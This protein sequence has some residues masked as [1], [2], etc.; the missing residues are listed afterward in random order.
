MIELFGWNDASNTEIPR[1][2]E[3]FALLQDQTDP[4]KLRPAVIVVKMM[5][6]RQLTWAESDEGDVL[7][8]DIPAAHFHCCNGAQ[9]KYWKAVDI[10]QKLDSC[11]CGVVEAPNDCF[12][13]EL[14]IPP[15]PKPKRPSPEGYWKFI[16]HCFA[17]DEYY[18]QWKCECGTVNQFR[19]TVPDLCNFPA[20]SVY[21]THCNKKLD[22]TFDLSKMNT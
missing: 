8:Y 16:P 12:E 19:K 5:P 9:I 15:E 22:V 18:V 20:F 3:I 7:C 17:P 13:A 21:C 6:A 14:A 4:E 2:R 10:P 1:N 11:V